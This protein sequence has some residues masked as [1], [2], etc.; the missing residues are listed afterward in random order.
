MISGRKNEEKKKKNAPMRLIANFQ[1]IETRK[2]Y[3]EAMITLRHFLQ[4]ENIRL[5]L[6]LLL[7]VRF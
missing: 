4:T 7:Q 2:T 6:Y 5:L 1:V 3:S